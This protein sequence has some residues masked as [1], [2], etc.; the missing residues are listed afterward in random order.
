MI[1][2]S[3]SGGKDFDQSQRLVSVQWMGL[4]LRITMGN[5]FHR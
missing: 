5:A 1:M 2:L 4:E 3:S